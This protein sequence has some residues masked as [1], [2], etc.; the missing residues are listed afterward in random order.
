MK[1]AP[2]EKTTAARERTTR[3][4]EGTTTARE[5]SFLVLSPFVAAIDTP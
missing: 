5:G 2:T 1:D 4:H 3:A